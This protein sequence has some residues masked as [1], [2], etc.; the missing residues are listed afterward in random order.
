LLIAAPP[1]PS[2][3]GTVHNTFGPSAAQDLNSPFSLDTAFLSG[4]RYWGQSEAKTELVASKIEMKRNRIVPIIF[5]PELL[6]KYSILTC[7]I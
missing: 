2:P 1:N 4:P 3:R 7:I 6:V 5:M